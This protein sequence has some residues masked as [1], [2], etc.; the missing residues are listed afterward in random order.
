VAG[1]H[2]RLPLPPDVGPAV[3]D[4]STFSRDERDMPRPRWQRDGVLRM[5]WPADRL[6]GGTRRS[7]RSSRRSGSRW[8]QGDNRSLASG[9]AL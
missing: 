8:R 5:R 6:R 2:E 9:A 1:C 7:W 4:A 3:L